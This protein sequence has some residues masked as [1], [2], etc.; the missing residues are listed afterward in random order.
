MKTRFI[1][2]GDSLPANV[3]PF[4]ILHDVCIDDGLLV[5]DFPQYFRDGLGD[6]LREVCDCGIHTYA[7]V[8]VE[9]PALSQ[10]QA[11]DLVR[12][13]A[14]TEAIY[15]VAVKEEF[16][17]IVPEDLKDQFPVTKSFGPHCDS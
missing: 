1:E 11:E 3:N 14:E 12:R 8:Q 15:E 7:P 17:H 16:Y 10:E 13:I 6:D 4:V 5:G 2:L 9:T